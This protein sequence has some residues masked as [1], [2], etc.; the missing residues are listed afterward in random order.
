M[1]LLRAG[2]VWV[3]RM[4]WSVHITLINFKLK[5]AVKGRTLGIRIHTYI[6]NTF[7]RITRNY[8]VSYEKG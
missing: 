1:G 6:Q 4:V 2:R 8:L 5:T 7:K 3:S